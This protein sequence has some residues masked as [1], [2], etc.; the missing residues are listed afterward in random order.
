[1]TIRDGV[2]VPIGIPAYFV[3]DQL[4]HG[5][6]PGEILTDEPGGLL[7][8]Y[9]NASGY[10]FSWGHL[11][12]Q[13]CTWREPHAGGYVCWRIVPVDLWQRSDRIRKGDART[14]VDLLPA[15]RM[16]SV[17]TLTGILPEPLLIVGVHP[18]TCRYPH[19]LL[20]LLLSDLRCEH[21]MREWVDEAFLASLFPT[22]LTRL[23]ERLR[24][25]CVPK[26][27][28]QGTVK[29]H[30]ARRARQD[31]RSLAQIPIMALDAIT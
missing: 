31:R 21:E 13:K 10:V 2:T 16:E 26:Q 19:T 29:A 30:G 22:L 12:E 4:A 24:N 23:E 5:V 3:T 1:M 11:I 6:D 7:D 17:R 18:K 14:V 25:L 27:R 20:T 15:L 28:G 8:E 9:A